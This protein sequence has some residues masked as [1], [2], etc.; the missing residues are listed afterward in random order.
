MP[1]PAREVARAR[2]PFGVPRRNGQRLPEPER[3]RQR[4][5]RQ[6]AAYSL[7][8]VHLARAVAGAVDD[9]GVELTAFLGNVNV[10][11]AAPHPRTGKSPFCSMATCDSPR[12]QNSFFVVDDDRLQAGRADVCLQLVA[13]AAG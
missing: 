3:V 7:E 2:S 5:E 4:R 9:R 10:V 13:N 11:A 6:A 12:C 8:A 1:G